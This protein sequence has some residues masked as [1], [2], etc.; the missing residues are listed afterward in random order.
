MAGLTFVASRG[1]RPVDDAVV[2][3]M[4][5]AAPHRGVSMPASAGA[6]G[7]AAAALG[8]GAGVF[9]GDA[10]SLIVADTRLDNAAAIAASLG[11]E[12]GDLDE[13]ALILAAYDRWGE[14]CADRLL[15]DFAFVIWD[16]R[17]S[18]VFAARDVLG[19]RPLYYTVTADRVLAASEIAQLLAVPGIARRVDERTVVASLIGRA[20]S[21]RWTHFEGVRRLR[22]GHML[23]ID[24]RGARTGAYWRPP[25]QSNDRELAGEEYAEELRLLIEAAVRARLG[26]TAAPGLM[27]SGGIDSTSVAVTAAALRGGDPSVAALRTYSFAYDRFPDSDERAVSDRLVAATGQPNRLVPTDDAFPLAG[28]PGSAPD[29]DGPDVLLSHITMERTLSLAR[30]DGVE[31]LMTG[32]RGDPLFGDGIV[33]YLGVLRA[34]GPVAL[35]RQAGAQAEREQKGRR[36]VLQR[37]L[38]RRIPA[39][40]WP[41]YRAVQARRW[42]RRVVPGGVPWSPWVRPEAV[43]AHG[44]R[45][46][47]SDAV[48]RSTLAGEARR[49]RH[50]A[51]VAPHH[52]LSAEYLERR[53]ARAGI[54]YADP[55]S[56]R[57]IADWVLSIPPHRITSDGA[58][59]W[60]LREAMRGL[61]PEFARSGAFRADPGS[62]YTYGLL[63]GSESAVRELLTQP[64]TSERGYV[65]AAVLMAA[66]ERYQGGHWPGLTEWNSFWRWV[67]L[68]RW[69]RIYAP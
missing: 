11:R 2:A 22:P 19:M 20:Q 43:A 52:A 25:H 66:Y 32:H 6:S 57:R 13:A 31:L 34:R 60:V 15:G 23:R 24:A 17:R 59:K 53:F 54:R 35:W 16:A 55:W 68:E 12:G 48:P 29:L 33:D 58:D 49:R 1:A 9:R 18:E 28:Y 61:L 8:N 56:D 40:I 37:D 41:S 47:A 27:L 62:V 51:I 14:G 3:G 39:A 26:A 64:L 63:E 10:G 45:W 38:A 65:D 7:A 36:A 67:A 30:A 42:L 5:A 46:G 44:L 50:D 69:L 21:P 4:A